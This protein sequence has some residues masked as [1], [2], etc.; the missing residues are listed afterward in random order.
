MAKKRRASPAQLAARK[1]FAERFGG[2]KHRRKAAASRPKRVVRRKRRKSAMGPGKHRPVV[3]RRKGRYYR[4]KRSSLP[5]KMTLANPFLGGLAMLGNSPM[6]RK[7]KSHKRRS[8]RRSSRRSRGLALSNPLP[9]VLSAPSQMIKKDFVT[10]AASV[11]AGFV[12][13]GMILPRLPV[14]MRDSTLKAYAAKVVIVAGLAGGAS[15]VNKRLS[16]AVLLGGGVSLLLDVWTDFVAP[17]VMRIGAPAAAVNAYYGDPG[18]PG[19]GAFYGQA[20]DPGVGAS[21]GD[22]FGGGDDAAAW[23]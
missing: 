5:R 15:L 2:K 1:K 3:I 12:I 7:R 8:H 17:S 23:G 10:E 14:S 11:A 19:V 6:A 13:P 9:A 21:I 18:D 20:G 22:A 16:R 4:P